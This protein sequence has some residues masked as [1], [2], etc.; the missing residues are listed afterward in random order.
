MAI[1]ILCAAGKGS[2]LGAKKPKALIELAGKPLFVHSLAKLP[3]TGIKQIIILVPPNYK[4]EFKSSIEQHL[5]KKVQQKIKAMIVGGNT[6]QNSVA[7]ALNYLHEIKIPNQEI[8]LVHNAANPFFQIKEL[9]ILIREVKLGYGCALAQP[10]VDTLRVV[11]QN[12]TVIK[13]LDRDYIWRTQTPQAARFGELK[14][15]ME[16]AQRLGQELTDEL[17]LL[18]CNNQPIKLVPTGSL[19]FK[20]TFARDLKIAEAVLNTQQ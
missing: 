3:L 16:R 15:A 9:K 6:R 5:N 2:R 4:Q 18:K 8:V 14:K 10:S 17:E 20:I 13:R 11:D 7:N 1:F 12:L 19:N